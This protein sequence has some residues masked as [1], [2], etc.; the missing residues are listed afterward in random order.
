MRCRNQAL[1]R[2]KEQ[3]EAQLGIKEDQIQQLAQ[4]LLH[5]RTR[6]VDTRVL[7]DRIKRSDTLVFCNSQNQQQLDWSRKSI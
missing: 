5:T 6:Q 3:L 2:I 1:I 7:L 4:Q